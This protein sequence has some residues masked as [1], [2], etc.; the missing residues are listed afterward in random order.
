MA[1]KCET[2][3]QAVIGDSMESGPALYQWCDLDTI[4]SLETPK[5]EE[6]MHV[7]KHLAKFKSR[8]KIVKSSIQL[9]SGGQTADVTIAN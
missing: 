3:P 6:G 4:K 2:Q 7:T 8:L 1:P 9:Y 5:G